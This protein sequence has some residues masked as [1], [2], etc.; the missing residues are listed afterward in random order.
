MHYKKNY[1]FLIGILGTAC[2]W[3]EYSYYGYLTTTI[4]RLFFPNYDTRTGL[5]ASLAIFAA[6]FIMRPIGGLFFGYIGDRKGRKSAL[7]LSLFLMGTATF[8][9]GM[10]PTY[11]TI[12]IVAPI[13]LLICRLTQGL[14]VS[15][16]FNGAAIFLI[17]HCK[18]NNC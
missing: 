11:N 3:L 7:F 8:L 10:I 13:L 12:G 5:L 1:T 15:G 4:S 6:G 17:E 16:E 18:N 14:A 2:E 9:M